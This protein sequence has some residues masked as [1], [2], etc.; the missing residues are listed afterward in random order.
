M[1]SQVDNNN[2]NGCTDG[3][4]IYTIK[5]IKNIILPIL[6]KY[7]IQDVYL[8]GSYA[9]GDATSSSDI[10]IYCDKGNIKTLIDQDE[11]E[12]ELESA[13]NK[14]VDIVFTSSRMSEQFYQNIKE[15]MIKL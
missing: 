13:L 12:S 10:D 5:Y 1:S 6:S 2:I 3:K 8:F 11:L 9:R 14:K 15:D 4:Q 7:S